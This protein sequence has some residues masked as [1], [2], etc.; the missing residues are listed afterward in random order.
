MTPSHRRAPTL[1]LWRP[2]TLFGTSQTVS[3]L[4]SQTTP[5]SGTSSLNFRSSPWKLLASD[6]KLVFTLLLW[7]PHIFLPW[8]STNP[9]SELYPSWKNMRD[10]GLHIVLGLLGF[11]WLII[12]VPVWIAAP[13]LVFALLMLLYCALTALFCVPL[14]YGP[15]VVQSRIQHVSGPEIW[16]HEKWVFVNGVAAGNHW[17]QANVDMISEIFGR[18]VTGIHNRTYGT[19]FDLVECLIQ[20]CFSYS[21][22]DTRVLYDHLKS[23]LLNNNIHKCV[24]IAH[25]QGGIILSTALDCLFADV[26]SGAFEKMEIYT[27]GCAANHFNNPI[28]FVPSPSQP[29]TPSADPPAPERLIKYIEHYCNEHDFVSRFGALHFSK[30]NLSNRFAGKVFENKGHGGHLLNQHYLDRMFAGDSSDFLEMVVEAGEGRAAQ[31]AQVSGQETTQEELRSSRSWPPARTEFRM[32]SVAVPNDL[33]Q[34]RTL[35]RSISAPGPSTGWDFAA[36][37]RAKASAEIQSGKT[38]MD[39]SRLWKY[40]NGES[41]D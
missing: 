10:L 39:L 9:Y 15:R 32:A 36:G 8:R 1:P 22:K 30:D 19:V 13:G 16:N 26:P 23:V 4:P 31:G 29:Q 41:P 12:V 34:T 6:I 24:V 7:V 27:F 25:S 5:D 40:K 28:R 11:F 20:R 35:G 2:R 3:Y 38:M 18:P 17:L 14:D 33:E 37:T 21:T